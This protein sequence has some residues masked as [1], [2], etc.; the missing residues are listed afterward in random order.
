MLPRTNSAYDAHETDRMA[1]LH[2]TPLASF[3]RRAGAFAVDFFITFP[4]FMLCVALGAWLAPRLGYPVGDVHLVYDFTHW[5]S[6]IFLVTYFTLWTYWTDG[7]SPG[8]WLFK[9]RVVSLVHDRLTFW[10]SLERSLGYGASSLEFG[11]G[12]LQFFVNRNRRTVH[13]RIAETIVVS[14]RPPRKS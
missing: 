4:V 3:R 13:D 9:I 8:K 1:H 11:F 10:Q 6:L 14:E 12:F 2:G 7:R 5:Y